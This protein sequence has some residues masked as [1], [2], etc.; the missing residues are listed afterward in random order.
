MATLRDER[1]R[2][3]LELHAAIDHANKTI[4]EAL[5][6][7]Y[8]P[9]RRIRQRWLLFWS[10]VFLTIAGSEFRAKIIK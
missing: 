5:T 6:I 9:R 1:E 10:N 3:R 8:D 2:L 4:E 7:D